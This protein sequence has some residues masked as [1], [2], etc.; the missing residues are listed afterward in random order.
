MCLFTAE[1]KK[2]AGP[3]AT[4]PQFSARVAERA[5]SARARILASID[6]VGIG[7]IAFIG[8]TKFFQPGESATRDGAANLRHFNGLGRYA[9]DPRELA[10]DYVPSIPAAD[11]TVA[12]DSYEFGDQHQVVLRLKPDA[13]EVCRLLNR[14]TGF[15]SAAVPSRKPAN[16]RDGCWKSGDGYRFEYLP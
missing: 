9:A 6:W 1:N 13:Y 15:S 3:S 14:S 11:P 10:G 2:A 16:S 12:A 5:R 7:T 4:W 8:T